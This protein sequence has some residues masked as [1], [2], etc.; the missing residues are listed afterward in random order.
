MKKTKSFV[1]QRSHTTVV[2]LLAHHTSPATLDPCSPG[3][4]S[5]LMEEC[6]SLAM[7]VECCSHFVPNLRSLSICAV[8][9]VCT[10][11]FYLM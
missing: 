11:L 9:T 2:C 5:F 7:N 3:G 6:R 8:R 4:C 1:T 10:G